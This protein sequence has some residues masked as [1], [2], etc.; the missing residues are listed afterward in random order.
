MLME[1]VMTLVTACEEDK[2]I[3]YRHLEQVGV[4]RM[5]ADIMAAE[6]TGRKDNDNEQKD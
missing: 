1:L 5:T 6:F 4:D 2:E 3:A